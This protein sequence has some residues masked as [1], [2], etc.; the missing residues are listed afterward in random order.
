[1]AAAAATAASFGRTR[2]GC[3]SRTPRLHGA[4]H[5]LLRFAVRD[6]HPLVDLHR[7]LANGHPLLLPVCANG[8][9]IFRVSIQIWPIARKIVSPVFHFVHSVHNTFNVILGSAACLCSYRSGH[10]QFSL[11]N[12]VSII[13]EANQNIRA[14]TVEVE[15]GQL[16]PPYLF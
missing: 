11:T 12:R 16:S 7:G 14:R 1:M 9:A 3:G 5:L 10:Y 8:K 4:V 15:D 6:G 13:K 2:R